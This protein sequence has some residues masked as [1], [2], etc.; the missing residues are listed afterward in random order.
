MQQLP[1]T[2]ARTHA[3]SGEEQSPSPESRKYLIFLVGRY[4]FALEISAIKR[5]HDAQGIP[6]RS[7]GSRVLDLHHLTGAKAER[8]PGY[9]IEMEIGGS[10]FLSPVEEVE[11]I[12]ELSLSVPMEYPPALRREATR[13]FR[14]VFFDGLRMIV[15]LDPQALAEAETGSFQPDPKPEEVEPEV[16]EPRSDRVALIEI[17][18]ELWRLDLACLVQVL[19]TEEIHSLPSA[20][21]PIEGVV[22]Y[23]DRAVPVLSPAR[24]NELMAGGTGTAEND[25]PSIA[26]VECRLGSLGIGCRWVAQVVGRA[27]AEAP[28]GRGKAEISPERLI[29]RLRGFKG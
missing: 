25:Y 16:A 2:G 23:A 1:R 5:V 29:H 7:Q 13:P 27:E 21:S 22:Y 28:P 9:W 20:G 6:P 26:L 3:G 4:S 11:E 8:A 10:R 12:R 14:R 15:E 19:T 24:F 17:G 18:H